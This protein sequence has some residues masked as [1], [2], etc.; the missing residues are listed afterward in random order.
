MQNDYNNSSC[1]TLIG[2]VQSKI[3]LLL[4]ILVIITVFNWKVVAVVL[5]MHMVTAVTLLS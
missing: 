5:H 4:D 2:H 3:K 1:L